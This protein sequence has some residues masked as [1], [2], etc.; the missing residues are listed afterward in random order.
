MTKNDNTSNSVRPPNMTQT[1]QEPKAKIPTETP[2]HDTHPHSPNIIEDDN[3]NQPQKL[4]HE[5]QPLGLGLPPQRNT[6][7]PHHIPPDSATSPRVAPSPRVAQ[8][9]RYQTRSHA[10]WPTSLKHWRQTN[11][12]TSSTRRLFQQAVTKNDRTSNSAAPPNM[13][14]T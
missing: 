7:T 2:K 13:T 3:R 8:P 9:P 10:R 5:N 6:S 4:D 14:Q 12:G 11:R 1:R